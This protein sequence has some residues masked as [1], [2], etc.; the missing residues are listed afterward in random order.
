M[1]TYIKLIRITTLLLIS[2]AFTFKIAAQQPQIKKRIAV[3]VFEDKTD[4]SWR[5]WNNK[6]VGNGVSDMLTTALVKSGNYRVIERQELDRILN[7]Q[8]FGQSGRITPQSAA[9]VGQVLGVELAVMGS[10]S[11]F[12]YKKGETG[13]AIKGLGIGVSN[14]AATVGIDVRMVNTSTGE[15]VTAEN[16]RKKKSAKG[17]K[18]RT[19]KL[20]FKDRKDFDESLVG[21]AAREAIED[22][23]SL[24]DNSANEIPWQAKVIIEKS[25][26]VFINSGEA[27]GLKA[28]DSFAVYSKGDDLIDPDT[29]ISLGSVDTKI[30]EIKITD[31]SI[32]NGKA[33]K[34]S[35]VQG[36]GF[37]KG[38]FVRL[39]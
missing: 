16:V 35:I 24:I 9:K 25:G 21:K 31:A 6:G 37:T 12:G 32:G 20:N 33:S 30:G 14:Q 11:E 27:D 34:C 29:G 7:E 18:L 10:V 39:K 22:I 23:V 5:W 1:K 36:S 8:D 3:F 28:G 13:G 17:I 19:N 26:V 15:I 4:R 38:N 2:C